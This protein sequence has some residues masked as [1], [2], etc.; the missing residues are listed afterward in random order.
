[1][2]VGKRHFTREQIEALRDASDWP[3]KAPTSE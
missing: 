1:M 2:G 3:E